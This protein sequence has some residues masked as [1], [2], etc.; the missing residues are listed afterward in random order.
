MLRDS[1]MVGDQYTSVME[2]PLFDNLARVQNSIPSESM[3]VFDPPVRA[4][5]ASPT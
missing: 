1:I 5:H 2:S 3:V 4:V